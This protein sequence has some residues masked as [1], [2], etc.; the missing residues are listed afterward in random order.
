[1][2]GGTEGTPGGTVVTIDRPAPGRSLEG[3]G[4]GGGEA[5]A[6]RRLHV[7]GR[8]Q[9]VGF[10][11]FVARLAAACGLAGWVKNTPVGVAIHLEGPSERL[12]EFRARLPREAPAEARIDEL[13]ADSVAPCSHLGSSI[14]EGEVRARSINPATNLIRDS[15]DLVVSGGTPIVTGRGAIPCPAGVG[16]PRHPF[17]GA[18]SVEPAY[19]R[20][21]RW[22]RGGWSDRWC[23]SA[24]ASSGRAPSGGTSPATPGSPLPAGTRPTPSGSTGPAAPTPRA[25]C[26][27]HPFVRR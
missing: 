19:A 1:M 26:D 8:V 22:K 20:A 11:P 18:I 13:R 12:D 21:W 5:V 9:G 7:A 3:E 2:V 15:K 14:D 10:R 27:H 25:E 23:A 24:E 16:W 6:A 4:S 17:Q